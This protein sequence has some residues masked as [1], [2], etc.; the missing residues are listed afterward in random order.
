MTTG[1]IRVG[2]KQLTTQTHED[3][4]SGTALTWVY[5]GLDLVA[6]VETGGTAALV[7]GQ[8]EAHGIDRAALKRAL[9]I[10]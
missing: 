7:F 2:R 9:G 10:V 4:S 3:A 5:R 6:T 8:P 1:T